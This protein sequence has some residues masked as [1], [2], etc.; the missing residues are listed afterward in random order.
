MKY[1]NE[2]REG[3]N[4]SEIYLCKSKQILQTKTGKSYYSLVLQDKT[5]TLDGKIWDLGPG[6]ENFEAMDYIQIN[7]QIVSFQSALQVNIK[8]LRKCS[9]GEYNSSEYMPCTKK[10]VDDM[11]RELMGIISSIKN[12]YLK[13]LAESFFINDK[14][15]AKAFVNH[16]AAK[17]VHH[18]FIGGLLEHSLSVTRN[19]N[20][21]AGLYPILNRDLLVTAAMLHDI[22]KLKELSTFPENDYTDE[23][24]LLGHIYVG[25]EMISRRADTIVNFPEK[26]KN[27]LLHCILAHHGELEYG[28]PKKPAL[29]EALV[30]SMMDNL[31]AKL[32]TLTE[33]FESTTETGWLG[34]QRN[35]DSNIRKTG[36]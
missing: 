24:N 14:A 22:G 30:L 28:S 17:T 11:Y 23:G 6:I 1:L 25:A 32:E 31:D 26:T 12:P 19:C 4:I 2:L 9:E 35:F 13:A 21:I 29:A 33:L 3:D 20:I 18:G 34:F 5:G 16:S 7:A 36:E 10:N 15:F 8:R 27:E